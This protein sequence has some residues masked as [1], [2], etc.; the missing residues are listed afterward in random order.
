MTTTQQQIAQYVQSATSQP[1]TMTS[2]EL[3]NFIN[4]L[5]EGG[6]VLTHKNFLAKVGVVLADM[7]AKFLAHTEIAGPNGGSRKSKM[8][9]FPK[10]EATL[11]A[12]SYSHEISAQVYDKMEALEKQA[13]GPVQLPQTYAQALMAA[14]LAAEKVEQQ[15]LALDMANRELTL[16]APKVDF[17]RKFV[18]ANDMFTATDVAK[19][20]SISAVRL[21]DWLD[22][23]DVLFAN[24]K[25]FKQW[26]I[27]RGFGVEKFTEIGNDVYSKFYHTPSGAEWIMSNYKVA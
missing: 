27:A 7:S 20:L 26:Y 9:I 14:A 22:T 24:R 5:R 12:M 11:M 25:H 21:N 19:K 15:Q 4:D 18:A 1:V 6:K 16:A 3:V 2:I 10:R 23:K 8:Y 17:H 13:Q